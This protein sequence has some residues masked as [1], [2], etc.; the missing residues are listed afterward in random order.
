MERND[1]YSGRASKGYGRD[2]RNNARAPNRSDRHNRYD[3]RESNNNERSEVRSSDYVPPLLDSQELRDRANL[4]L[5]PRPP[6][7]CPVR[8]WDNGLYHQVPGVPPPTPTLTGNSNVAVHVSGARPKVHER[9]QPSVRYHNDHQ[10]DDDN[11][12][13]EVVSRRQSRLQR[14][15]ARGTQRGLRGAPE[16]DI[17]YLYITFCDIETTSEE[18]E[19]HIYEH[20]ERVT[21]ARARSTAR[22]HDDYAA[23]TVRVT[24]N[25]LDADDFL[26]SDIFPKPIKVYLNRNKYSE[27]ER[28]V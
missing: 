6:A 23:F 20:Y 18:V 28:G 14:L 1:R 11:T 3:V 12:F 8:Q 21:Q 24:G 17:I 13:Q 16:P 7:P 22:S 9:Q 27:E 2:D 19:L 5:D 26:N 15:Q 4:D 25:D 10:E